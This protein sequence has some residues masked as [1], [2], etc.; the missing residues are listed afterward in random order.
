MRAPG[1]APERACNGCGSAA[2]AGGVRAGLP[3]LPAGLSLPSHPPEERGRE[4][5]QASMAAWVRHH[6]ALPVRGGLAESPLGRAR[7]LEVAFPLVVGLSG[8]LLRDGV[9]SREV[10]FPQSSE[11]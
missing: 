2:I 11:D 3:G 1:D 10:A 6:R 8:D 5:E 7:P 9:R 4:E